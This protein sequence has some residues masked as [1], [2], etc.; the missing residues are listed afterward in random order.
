MRHSYT[1]N[2][3]NSFV[4]FITIALLFA[5]FVFTLPFV[6]E[7]VYDRTF[8]G[9]LKDKTERLKNTDGKRI[10]VIGGSSVPFALKGELIQEN[11]AEYTYVDFGLYLNIGTSV[12]C[13]IAK[14]YI[15]QGDIIVISPEQTSYALSMQYSPE[16]ILQATDSCRN[17]LPLILRGRHRDIIAAIP[18]HSFKKALYLLRGKP[19]PD[20]IYSAT[21]F[22]EYGDVV[23]PRP[24]NIMADKK[25]SSTHIAF[26]ADMISQ[27]FTDYLNDFARYCVSKG[28]KIY[29]HFSPM[30]SLALQQDTTRLSIR[31]YYTALQE[32]LLFYVIGNPN[33]CILQA[34]YFYDTN[35]HLN[36]SGA[37]AYTKLFIDDL[38]TV[39][40]DT[41]VTHVNVPSCPKTPDMQYVGDDSQ[42]DLFIFEE[43]KENYII[44]DF[45]PGVNTSHLILPTT[46]NNKSIIGYKDDLF[47]NK[48]FI[49]TITI[50]PNIRFIKDNSFDGCSSL[51]ALILDSK[52]P[53]SY[54]IGDNLMSQYN[55]R[56]LVPADA[57]DTYKTDYNFKK[58][59]R[60]IY[61]VRE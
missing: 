46:Y 42:A 60:Y 24:Y 5:F 61:P 34:E 13:D 23:Y 47:I 3:K 55:F 28:A 29:Y 41:S 59:D 48:E 58:Y 45:A 17:I 16:D 25:D 54:S 2:S 26:D 21:S 37:I 9:G 8:L 32:K 11:L 19:D 12:M 22:D 50:Q 14:P 27:S 36:D 56:I 35:F 30:N 44:A 10:I 33:D 49:R 38:K 39:L 52:S 18:R 40:K 31:E 6:T 51:N 4:P 53:S 1:S 7:S 15:H 57:L 20:G 43:Y